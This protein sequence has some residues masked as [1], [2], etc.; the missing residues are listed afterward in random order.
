MLGKQNHILTLHMAC[1][2]IWMII[3]LLT[4]ILAFVPEKEYWNDGVKK[5]PL[6]PAGADRLKYTFIAEWKVVE[7]R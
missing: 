7:Y 5:T 4:C 3:F 2:Y 6:S 1:S